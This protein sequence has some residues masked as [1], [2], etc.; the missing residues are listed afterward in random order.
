M[1]TPLS[2]HILQAFALQL[3]FIGCTC[4]FVSGWGGSLGLEQVFRFD[5]RRSSSLLAKILINAPSC[6]LVAG[7]NA[8]V[9]LLLLFNPAGEAVNS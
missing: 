5:I 3:H 6:P 4:L 2:T 8:L 7:L 9:E 1:K